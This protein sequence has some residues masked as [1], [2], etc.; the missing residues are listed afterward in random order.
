MCP[1]VRKLA[2]QPLPSRGSIG[3]HETC[4]L[5]PWKLGCRKKAILNELLRRTSHT[6]ESQWNMPYLV[7]SMHL[8]SEKRLISVHVETNTIN[9]SLGSTAPSSL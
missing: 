4:L 3:Q 7:R 8:R 5:K 1:R 2:A 9:T 6:M